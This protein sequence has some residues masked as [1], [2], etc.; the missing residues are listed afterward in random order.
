M[1]TLNETAEQRELREAVEAQ[2]N[3]IS[4]MLS[5]IHI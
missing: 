2:R 1:S 5:L 4:I 3:H